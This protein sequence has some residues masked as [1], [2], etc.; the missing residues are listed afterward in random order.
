[1]FLDSSRIGNFITTKERYEIRADCPFCNDEKYHLYVNVKKQVFHC[2]RCGAKGKTNVTNILL[3]NVVSAKLLKESEPSNKQPLK[4]PEPCDITLSI[5]ARNYL[6]TRG[7]QE[8]DVMRHKIYSAAPTSI[9]CGRIIISSNPFYGFANYFVG[10]SYLKWILPKYLNPPGGKHK[11]FISPPMEDMYHKQL[12]GNHEVLLVE[13]PFDYL[14]A[15]RHGPCIALLGKHLPE[16]HRKEILTNYGA[17]YIML[18]RGV[19]ES[20]AAIKIRDSLKNYLLKVNILECPKKDPG[21]ME[22]KDFEELFK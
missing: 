7:L 6:F 17:V 14:K 10:R 21:E 16:A 11:P 2:F 12:W 20:I 19:K 15:S 5:A 8:S 18:D 13:G 3:S 22:P 1:M 9:Y 4:L